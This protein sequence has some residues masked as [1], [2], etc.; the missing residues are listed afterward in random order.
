M[1][2]PEEI[3]QIVPFLGP[4]EQRQVLDVAIRLRDARKL[5]DITLPPV[6]A[7]DTAW[8]A[9]RE[10]VHARSTVVMAEEKQRLLALGLI[11]EHWTPLTNELPEDMLPSSKTSVET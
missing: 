7:D 10:R 6:E 2:I 4:A 9:W 1:T 5:P 8:V 3:A 11:D